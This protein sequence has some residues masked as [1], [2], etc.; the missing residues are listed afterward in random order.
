MAG[1]G[2]RQRKAANTDM[3]ILWRN[4]CNKKVTKKHI[5]ISRFNIV[6][7]CFDGGNI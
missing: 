7:R 4:Q 1:S 3:G 5:K 6:F 2:T